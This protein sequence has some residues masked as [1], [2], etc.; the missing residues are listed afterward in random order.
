MQKEDC[1]PFD[2]ICDLVS[3]WVVSLATAIAK[4]TFAGNFKIV[5]LDAVLFSCWEP[6]VVVHQGAHIVDADD[7]ACVLV[8]E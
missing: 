6:S 7:W 1:F 5:R 3:Y 8:C 2:S 4:R